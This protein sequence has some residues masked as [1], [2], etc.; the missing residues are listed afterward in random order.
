MGRIFGWMTVVSVISAIL[1]GRTAALA[2]GVFAGAERA[3]T[4]TLALL[5]MLCLWCGVLAVL[6][7]GGAITRLSRLLSPL[8]RAIFPRA[9][10]ST[11]G[12]AI[13]ANLS[14]N[15]LGVGNAATP[16]ALTAMKQ[17]QAENPEP[18]VAS[19]DMITFAVLNC[20]SL[21]LLPT[22][23]LTLRRMAGSAAPTAV[24]PV[25]LPVSALCSLCAILLCRLCA[26]LFPIKDKGGTG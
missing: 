21:S 23:L 20:S 14:A 25:I 4:Q 1:T 15:L 12:E 16:F 19:D 10:R 11:A 17:M 6:R 8:M 9:A 5:G 7:A 2:E 18:T 24:I 22:T 3:V 26:R 13:C